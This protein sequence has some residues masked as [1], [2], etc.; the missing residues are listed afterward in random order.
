MPST[1]YLV[2]PSSALTRSTEITHGNLLPSSLSN[3][4]NNNNYNYNADMTIGKLIKCI[5]ISVI[6]EQLG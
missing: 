2:Q 4:N 5:L 6:G 3:N 1:V